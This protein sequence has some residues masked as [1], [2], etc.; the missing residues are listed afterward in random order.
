MPIV[1]AASAPV[2]SHC[3]RSWP[4]PKAPMMSGIA[5]LTVVVVSTAEMVPSITVTVANQR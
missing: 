5:T 1:M 4:M 2:E 3:A